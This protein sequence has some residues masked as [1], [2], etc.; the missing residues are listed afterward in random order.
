MKKQF[1]IGVLM[2]MAAAMAFAQP[3][4]SDIQDNVKKMKERLG[5]RL[6]TDA[7]E[8]MAKH[9]EAVGGKDAI[10]SVKKLMFKGRAIYGAEFARLY[11]YYQQPNL[12]RVSTSPE[13]GS[14]TLTDGEKVWAVN[15][16]GR[17]ELQGWVAQSLSH[18]RIDGNFIDYKKRGIKVEY[19]GLED[20]GTGPGLYYHLRR[21]FPDGFMEELYFDAETGLL[22]GD[23]PASSPQKIFHF[24]YD[25]R[26]IGS[27][28]MAHMW[29]TV[30]DRASP[31]HVLVIEEV[32]V[33]E[34][35]GQAFF[36]EYKDKPIQ[37]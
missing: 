3:A 22:F 1:F 10:L 9:V 26:K 33:N 27:I 31:P 8:V 2:V 5:A 23:C 29:V 17:R 14:Y 25:Y 36:T 16:E 6:L 28:F 34:D 35:F 18:H 11:R 21:T 7:D 4:A 32:R 20:F 15:P 24:Y 19:V 30:A 12:L 37:K 13:G